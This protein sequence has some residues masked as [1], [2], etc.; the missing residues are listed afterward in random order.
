MDISIE[1]VEKQIKSKKQEIG[2]YPMFN[3]IG[4]NFL[5]KIGF[6]DDVYR[7]ANFW[8]D[9]IPKIS[10]P[11]K[12]LE[13]G[14]RYGGN[15]LTIAHSYCKDDLSEIHCIDPWKNYDEY[16]EK[17]VS[18]TYDNIYERFLTYIEPYKDKFIIHRGLSSD[19]VPKFS[20]NYFDMIYIDGNHDPVYVLED[21]IMCF[22]KL[23][24]GGYMIFDDFDWHSANEGIYNFCK[25]K[26]GQFDILCQKNC[27]FFIK[28]HGHLV[29]VTNERASY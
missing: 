4:N 22:E 24:P 10:G 19:E 8:F 1:E 2:D 21:A 9:I 18:E 7:T 5:R 6:R 29:H 25:I 23:K 28:K 27:Q 14:V 26:W 20:N 12:Y 13:I 16:A 3:E 11:V 17:M 15:V